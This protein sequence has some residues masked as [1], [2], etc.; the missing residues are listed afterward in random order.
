M[1]RSAVIIPEF[2]TQT[3]ATLSVS[4]PEL[5]H[6]G[7]APFIQLT[8]SHV[9]E[10]LI[11]RLARPERFFYTNAAHTDEKPCPPRKSCIFTQVE[12]KWKLLLIDR[13]SRCDSRRDLTGDQ[14]IEM[15]GRAESSIGSTFGWMNEWMIG[16]RGLQR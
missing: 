12:K 8:E 10:L 11:S 2:A 4:R 14:L 15:H 1:K 3:H 9:S 6:C 7:G 13:L 5:R 16:W